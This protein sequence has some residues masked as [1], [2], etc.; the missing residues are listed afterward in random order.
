MSY[1][2][3][4]LRLSRAVPADLDVVSNNIPTKVKRNGI[5][6]FLKDAVPEAYRTTLKELTD[7]RDKLAQ[8]EEYRQYLERVA[9]AANID[10]T[11]TS[12][13]S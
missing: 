4:A 6:T 3:E 9:Y 11:E 12:N 1:A 8:L 5:S 10:L 7:L 13:G 2:D